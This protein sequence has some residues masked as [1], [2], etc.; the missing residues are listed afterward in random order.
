V[1]SFLINLMHFNQMNVNHKNVSFAFS[2][3]S[4]VRTF[5]KTRS[6]MNMLYAALAD[7]RD[8][9]AIAIKNLKTHALLF[10][11]GF[12]IPRSIDA[13]R[14]CQQKRVCLVES[15]L[16]SWRGSSPLSRISFFPRDATDL[17]RN[18]SSHQDNLEMS[19][20]PHPPN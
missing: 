10:D 20:L 1:I 9:S 3:A 5:A 7:S 12:L 6:S 19:V 14:H 17:P 2:V 18:T 8:L 4:A 15:N 16:H 11:Q 13:E